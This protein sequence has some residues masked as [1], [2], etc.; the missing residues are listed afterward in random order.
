MTATTPATPTWSNLNGMPT[1]REH[2]PMSLASALD[3]TPDAREIR[4]PHDLWTRITAADL[5]AAAA[6]LGSMA[7][8]RRIYTCE[9]CRHNN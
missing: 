7:Q 1:C 8:A 6:H 2:A 3:L 5:H 9:T 4:T